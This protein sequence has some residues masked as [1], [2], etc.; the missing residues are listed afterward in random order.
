MGK[1]AAAFLAGISLNPFCRA[2]Q[3]FD[4]S[5][6][7][8]AF[9]FR[10]RTEQT[11]E[12]RGFQHRTPAH[13]SSPMKGPPYEQLLTVSCASQ[14]SHLL[15]AAESLGQSRLRQTH[16]ASERSLGDWLVLI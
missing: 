5:Y 8:P 16:M 14:I 13:G 6:R 10:K 2:S 3:K 15:K 12:P 4:A 7:G 9:S 1:K 11:P